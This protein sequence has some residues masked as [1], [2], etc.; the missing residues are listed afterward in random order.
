MDLDRTCYFSCPNE[1]GQLATPCSLRMILENSMFFCEA[2]GF[3]FCGSD[4]PEW[5]G[6]ASFAQGDKNTKEL[7]K[8]MAEV[9][10]F[11][12]NSGSCPDE[13]ILNQLLAENRDLWKLFPQ[14]KLA[15]IDL[16]GLGMDLK[17]SSYIFEHDFM[18]PWA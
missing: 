5:L 14:E 7:Q 16:S 9:Y 6:H 1:C 17:K 4:F 12:Y 13:K 10:S 11:L 2:C 15:R 18:S 8:T 3:E